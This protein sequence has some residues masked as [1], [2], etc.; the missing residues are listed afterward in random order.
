MK[1][2]VIFGLI[3]ASLI[4]GAATAHAKDIVLEATL[5]QPV[6]VKP[7]KNGNEYARMIIQE[8]RELNGIKYKADVM[9]MCFGEMAVEKAQTFTTGDKFRAIASQNDYRGNT[10]YR[11]VQFI[12]TQ[13][14]E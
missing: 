6:T 1:K 11:I 13:T 3:A 4:I 7:D 10:S 5:S 9:V 14:A 8:D 2:L 12:P